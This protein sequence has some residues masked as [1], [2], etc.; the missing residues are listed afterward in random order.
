MFKTCEFCQIEFQPRKY[1]FNYVRF[2]SK[3]CANKSRCPTTPTRHVIERILE[4]VEIRESGGCWLWT[5]STDEYGYGRIATSKGHAPR[6]AY[7]VLYEQIIG[8]V[9]KG[10]E[11]DHLC[12]NRLCV[13][14]YHLEP[15]SHHENMLRGA[16]RLKTHCPSGH[17]YNEANTYWHRTHRLCRIC[18]DQYYLRQR[19]VKS[20][21]RILLGEAT[22][23]A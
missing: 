19:L 8:A 22:N 11:L 14:P 10:L 2:C 16:Q 4:K 18:R 21:R 13:N 23:Y 17:S 7:R 3:S 12:R 20:A 9:P 1:R 6:K 15:V 5:R